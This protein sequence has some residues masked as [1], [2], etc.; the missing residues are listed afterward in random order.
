MACILC[1]L[2]IG[3]FHRFILFYLD[4]KVT[5]TGNSCEPLISRQKFEFFCDSVLDCLPTMSNLQTKGVNVLNVCSFSNISSE[6]MYHLL[7]MCHFAKIVWRESICG[8]CHTDM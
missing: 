1:I 3:Y 6:D 8:I 5:H 4:N 7:V 2:V